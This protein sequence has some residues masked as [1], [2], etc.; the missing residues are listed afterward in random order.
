MEVPAEVVDVSLAREEVRQ[1]AG[2]VQGLAQCDVSHRAGSQG[3][4]EAMVSSR[5]NL[6]CSTSESATAALNALA[7]LARRM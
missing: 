5:D 2:V 1:A 3:S 4:R 6:P 7:V